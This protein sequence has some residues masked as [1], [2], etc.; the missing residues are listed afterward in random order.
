MKKILNESGHERNR[1]AGD[2]AYFATMV[3]M[4]REHFGEVHITSF[5]DRLERD[6]KRYD[7]QTVYSGGTIFK[8]IGSLWNILSTIMN[9]DVYVWGSGQILRDDTG[10]KSPLYRLSRPLIAKILGKPVMAYAVGIGPLETRIARLLAKLVLNTFDLITVRE[11]FS[12]ELLKSI[13][14]SKPDI[15]LTVDPAFALKPASSRQVT[16]ALREI[17]IEDDNSSLIGIAPFGPAFRGV[18]SLL[19]AK[20]QVKLDMWPPNGREK[21]SKHVQ[22]MAQACDYIV[23]KYKA[24]L[25]FFAQDASWQGLDDRIA[26]DIISHMNHQI[27]ARCLNNDDYS[28]S[29]I[30][31]MMGRME[32]VMGG[33]M[34][35]LIL[36]SGIGIP[37]LGLCFE[38]KIKK[39]G[40]TIVQSEY[41]VDAEKVHK[42][43]DL[44][45]IIDQLWSHRN[46]I[47]HDLG[48]RMQDLRHEVFRNVAR[49]AVLLRLPLLTKQ[50]IL[51]PCQRSQIFEEKAL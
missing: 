6:R 50:H 25:I 23:E 13:G 17:G 9:C 30:K 41:F 2:E 3:E 22:I 32:F 34:H 5:S 10:I 28:P 49:L 19:P 11:P 4:F 51:E 1:N 42:T 12:R 38:Q 16:P 46:R 33:R 15:H 47:R 21:Y 14:V 48:I 40:E 26:R 36:A 35:S 8:T 27:S 29:V 20:Y 45:K 39:F 7:V 31:G 24:K 37:V 18:R 44:T 43:K